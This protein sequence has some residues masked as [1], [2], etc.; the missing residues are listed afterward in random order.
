[1]T[2]GYDEFL[3]ID[4]LYKIHDLYLMCE[5]RKCNFHLHIQSEYVLRRLRLSERHAQNVSL[6]VVSR[7]H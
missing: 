3:I 1:M 6:S 4:V 5:V 7:E 2:L